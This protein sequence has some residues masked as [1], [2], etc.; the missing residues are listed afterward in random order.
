MAGEHVTF[1]D[2]NVLVYAHDRSETDRRP[3]AQA[4]L[5]ALWRE[6]TGALST[7]VL[8]EF[9]V[10]ATRKFDPPMRRV[11]ARRIV[12][13]YG[14]WT[15]VQV[16]VPLVLAASTLEERH[17]LSFWDALV[18]EAARRCGATRLLTEDL[19]AGRRIGGVRI[20]N[21]FA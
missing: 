8:Q 10:V 11:A 15:T 14:E 6:R 20:E 4:V 17:T 2:T 5:E 9:Y 7:Q 19:Q 13:L 3:V 16:D 21:P 12:G 1:V 18:I